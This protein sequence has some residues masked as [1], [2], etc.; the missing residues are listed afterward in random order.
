MRGS[1]NQEN[2]LVSEEKSLE[3]ARDFVEN[4]P[5]YGFDGFNLNHTETLYPEIAGHPDLYTFIFEF[6]SSHGGYGDR[7]G[8][9]VTQVIT[10]HR[11]H[12]T[13]DNGEVSNAV[14][15]SEWDMIEQEYIN[16][17]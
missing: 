9:P 10:P 1:G 15:D 16:Q 2:D 7:T 5:T 3:I 17:D 12:I 4:S 14:L 8:E 13:V 6:K 11:A